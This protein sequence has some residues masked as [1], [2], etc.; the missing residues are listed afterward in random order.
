MAIDFQQL[1][2]NW[3]EYLKIYTGLLAM[4]TP[5]AVVA[6]FLALTANQTP[7]ERGQVAL[8][9]CVSYLVVVAVLSYTGS[10]LLRLFGISVDAF[11]IA[12]GI[13]LL[14]LGLDMVRKPPEALSPSPASAPESLISLS[15]VPLTIPILAGPATMSS[16]VVFAGEHPTLTH[17]TGVALTGAWVGVT[18]YL[19]L[20]GASAL[21]RYF[22][23]TVHQVVQ[24]LMGLVLAAIAI[25]FMMHGAARHF[26]LEMAHPH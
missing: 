20:R 22:T 14:L 8:I 21:Q 18:L 5:P 19:C 26:S 23:P 4:S 6:L 1:F 7:R 11:Q 25:E 15:L 16:V 9:S 24:R 3:H 2:A 13:L 10:A 17:R 12:G